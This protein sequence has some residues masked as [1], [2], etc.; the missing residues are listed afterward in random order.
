MNSPTTKSANKRRPLAPKYCW[1]YT[2]NPDGTGKDSVVAYTK[3]EARALIKREGN[4]DLDPGDIITRG[5]C[6][7]QTRPSP[8]ATPPAV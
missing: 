4:V 3:S 5:E 8:D 6:L 2:F 1:W 7:P